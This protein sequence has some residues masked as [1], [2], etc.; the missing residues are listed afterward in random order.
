MELCE[1]SNLDDFVEFK[2]V[3]KED[4]LFCK[5]YLFK[6]FYLLTVGYMENI[7]TVFTWISN[8]RKI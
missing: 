8:F 7:I 4:V 2:G 5:S 6:I 1:N 3:L